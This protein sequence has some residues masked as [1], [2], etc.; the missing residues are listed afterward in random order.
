MP[1]IT[2]EQA[3]YASQ[4]TDDCHLAARSPGFLDA[5]LTEAERLCKG[6]GERPA[7]LACPA[8]VFVKPLS[9]TH[10]AVVQV[11][12]QSG[13]LG[14]RLLAV[15]YAAYADLGGDNVFVAR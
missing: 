5:W 15:P 2:I 10:V 12:D 8:A 3:R 1:D 4:G 14:F 9:K 13:T 6:F 11:A 7:D